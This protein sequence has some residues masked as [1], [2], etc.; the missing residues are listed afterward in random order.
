MIAIETINNDGVLKIETNRLDQKIQ[1][2]IVDNNCYGYC[3]SKLKTA[4]GCNYF[5]VESEINAMILT[6]SE[7]MYIQGIRDGVSFVT[8]IKTL[9]LI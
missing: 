8:H 4:I 9:D 1:S 2:V 5:Q 7:Q 6:I 3:L